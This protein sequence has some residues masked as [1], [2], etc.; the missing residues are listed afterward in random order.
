[1]NLIMLAM[2]AM[3]GG[4]SPQQFLQA[5]MQNNPELKDVMQMIDG[6]SPD[7]YMQVAQNL[8]ASQGQDLDA[9][10]KQLGI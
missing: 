2:Q 6:R 10:R 7:E 9:L 5:Q 4:Q 8:A 3:R 1:M